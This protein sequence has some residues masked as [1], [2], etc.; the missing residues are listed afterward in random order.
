MI[1]LIIAH[2]NNNIN[3][4][5]KINQFTFL[6]IIIYDKSENSNKLKE[7]NNNKYKNIKI[8]QRLNAGREGETYINHIILNYNEF[9][10]NDYTIFCQDDPFEHQPNFIQLI[11]F[12]CKYYKLK[13]KLPKYLPLNSHA[14]ALLHGTLFLAY[15]WIVWIL[16][17]A[18]LLYPRQDQVKMYLD[19]H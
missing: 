12:L 4:I 16:F 14:Y 15:S 2:Y 11:L 5:K 6:K 7:Y 17:P 3:W 13:N 9:N 18:Y 19:N 1:Y 8:I 10:K